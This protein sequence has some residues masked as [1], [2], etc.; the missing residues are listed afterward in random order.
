MP[1]AVRILDL[2]EHMTP[3]GLTPGP[4]SPDVLIGF[5][6]AWRAVGAAGAAGIKAL[7]KSTDEAIDKAEKATQAAS[8][9]PAQAGLKTTEETLKATTAT[10]NASAFAGMAGG[11]DTHACIKPL[12]VPPH[13]PGMVLDGSTTVFINNLPATRKGDHVTEPVGPPNEIKMGDPTVLIDG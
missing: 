3:P 1:D 4:G 6:P 13:G 2:V 10:A 7:K 9:T 8:G 12:P 11:A 5:K